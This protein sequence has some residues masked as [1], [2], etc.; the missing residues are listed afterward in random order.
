VLNH[1]IELA[2]LAFLIF[3]KFPHDQLLSVDAVAHLLLELL[4]GCLHPM[5]VVLG[6]L[7]A[8]LL[9][10]TLDVAPN[11]AHFEVGVHLDNF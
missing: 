6:G 3:I 11:L 7:N 9:E 8:A 5:P 4:Q 1:L 10:L 2:Q